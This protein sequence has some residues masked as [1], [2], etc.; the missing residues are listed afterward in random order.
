MCEFKYLAWFMIV[1]ISFRITQI[2][3]LFTVQVA[4]WKWFGEFYDCRAVRGGRSDRG[5]RY[6]LLFWFTSIAK[7]QPI[8]FRSLRTPYRYDLVLV[9]RDSN[10]IHLFARK[11]RQIPLHHLKYITMQAGH[12]EIGAVLDNF[13]SDFDPLPVPESSDDSIAGQWFIGHEG[14]MKINLYEIGMQ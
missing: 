14:P 9:V 2:T 11:I 5:R 6:H 4:K 10:E 7:L 12:C 13:Q 1:K 3:L 8:S